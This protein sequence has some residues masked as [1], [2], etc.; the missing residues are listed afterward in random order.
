MDIITHIEPFYQVEFKD[1]ER[2][3]KNLSK[4]INLNLLITKKCNANC[5]HCCASANETTEEITLENTKKIVDIARK[6]DVFYFVITGGEPLTHTHFWDI[7]DLIKD[8]FGIILNTNGTLIDDKTAKRLSEYDIASIHIS[9]DAPNEDIYERQRGNTTKLSEVIC[10]IKNLVKYNANVT[11]KFIITNINK[12]YLEE[13]IKL[14]ESLGVK[15]MSLAWFKSVGR[16]ILNENQLLIKGEEV[17]KISEK[18]YELREKHKDKIFLSFDDTQCFPF[19]FK[20]IKNLKYRKL[21]GDFFFRVNYNG[22]VY[23]CPFMENKVG[24]VLEENLISIWNHPELLQQRK[25]AWG[26]N[27]KG[28]CQDCKQNIICAG[29]CRARA[30]SAYQTIDQKDPLCWVKND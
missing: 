5:V 13:V 8:E 7:L 16:G 10:G 11:T 2:T 14:S 28:V 12:D 27:L 18:L 6:N 19:L 29:G 24:N 22:D 26:K 20:D 9:L 1:G 23:P 4:P 15:R 25:L 3:V 17:K 21:C 30:M